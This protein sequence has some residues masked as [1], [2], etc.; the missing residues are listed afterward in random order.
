M[1]ETFRN[2]VACKCFRALLVGGLAL[3][4][5]LHGSESRAAISIESFS[6]ATNDRFA[7]DSSFIAN[8]YDLSGVGRGS[9]EGDT[10]LW[11][12]LIDRNIFVSAT[13]FHPENDTEVYFY[14]GND[15][16]VT[17]ITRQ[18]R[19]STAEGLT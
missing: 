14:P 8:G 9:F 15:P 2:A 12:T 7:N 19:K 4:V 17:P 13:H 6:P 16:N 11:A 18:R 3:V 10:R 5:M 1:K